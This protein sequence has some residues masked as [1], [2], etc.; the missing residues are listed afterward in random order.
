MKH[1]I[2]LAFLALVLLP[3][4]DAAL[5][6]D[7]PFQQEAQYI[8]SFDELSNVVSGSVDLESTAASNGTVFLGTNQFGVAG[9]TRL[10]WEKDG[11]GVTWA[12]GSNLGIAVA[13]NRV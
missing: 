5:N 10:Y 11:G 8:A 2:P 9:L 1:L 3:S 13:Q 7:R 4:A 6:P 12:E